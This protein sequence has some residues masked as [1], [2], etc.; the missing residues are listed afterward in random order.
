[1][2]RQQTKEADLTPQELNALAVTA[3]DLPSEHH[4]FYR[5]PQCGEIID[6]R[7]LGD[8]LLHEEPHT[9][10]AEVKAEPLGFL[11][12][13][14]PTLV[15]E[16]PDGDEWTHEIKY[17]GYRTQIVIDSSGVRAFTRNGFDWSARY[18]EVLAAA[19][20]LK[21]GSAI[22]DGEMIVQDEQGRSDFDGFK[23]AL[24]QEPERLVF[25][26]FDLLRLNGED[27]RTMPLIERR[28]RLQELVGCH[29]PICHLQYSEHV[30]GAGAALFDAADQMGL[31]GIVSKKM[32][33]RYRSGRSQAWLKVKCWAEGLFVVTAVEPAKDGPAMAILA[34]DTGEELTPIGAAAVT[35]A[36][37]ERE[38]F[39]RAVEELRLKG[40][41]AI[42]N[43]DHQLRVPARFLK[44]SNELRHATL[45]AVV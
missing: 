14:L 45:C 6:R 2:P 25:M 36:G 21:C 13:M 20:N 33:S 10:A 44:G 26:C 22:L 27:M 1:V 29:D 23:R 32:S 37:A 42:K 7:Q 31:E 11:E 18:R 24:S 8:V 3:P 43:P 30:A 19:D 35:L 34:Q 17:D 38:R 12:P 5:C 16:P 41:A 28:Q 4:H 40:A 15:L 39:W 9:S